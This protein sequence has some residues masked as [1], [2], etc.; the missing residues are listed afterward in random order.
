VTGQ[1]AWR[2]DD[3]PTERL[4]PPSETAATLPYHPEQEPLTQ[5]VQP[6]QQTLAY[7]VK[8]GEKQGEPAPAAAQEWLR[9]GPGV[10][11]A[12]PPQVAAIWHG[13]QQPERKRRK[14]ALA[15]WLL[16]FA[17]LFAVIA[18]LIWRR[19]GAPLTVSAATVRAT[20]AV[21]TCNHA[22]TITGEMQTN[23]AQGTITYQWKRSDGT[24]SDVL[25]QQ[26]VKGSHQVDVSLLWTF[27]GV[28]D[29]RATATLDVLSPTTVSAA[30][31]FTYT[32]R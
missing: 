31:T 15:G 32:C 23:G 30:T 10:P 7:T 2:P 20:P 27:D 4:V 25:Q 3:A 14:R 17:V 18:I 16:P 26:V 22:A 12:V 24:V 28:G 1:S 9:F 21:V 11:A 8:Q 29:L 5:P 13:E 6:A 19:T